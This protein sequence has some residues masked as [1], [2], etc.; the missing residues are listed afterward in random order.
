MMDLFDSIQGIRRYY[1]VL[2]EAMSKDGKHIFETSLDQSEGRDLK[3]TEKGV[4]AAN[5]VDT[6]V[7]IIVNGIMEHQKTL[8]LGNL[9]NLKLLDAGCGDSRSL[10]IGTKFSFDCYGLDLSQYLINIS[11]KA[12][13]E[14]YQRGVI[15]KMFKV[16]KGSYNSD[17][18]YRPLGISFA[19]IDYFVHSINSLSCFDLIKKFANE[20]KDDAKLI[21]LGGP[22]LIELKEN[23]K[24]NDLSMSK[25]YRSKEK[26]GIQ[27]HYVFLNK[28]LN[29]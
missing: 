3:K 11:Q 21:L 19:D 20:A 9:E 2:S 16:T 10:A 29:P 22:G 8:D 26:I 4:F 24:E 23:V 7:D 5:T 6:F 25:L 1:E 15:P 14:L 13:S 12:S 28:N 27:G 17:D 18:D